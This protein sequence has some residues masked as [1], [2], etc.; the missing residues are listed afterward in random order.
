[1]SD[2][3]KHAQLYESLSALVDD[4]ASELEVHRLLAESEKDPSL[5]T[6]WYRYQLARAALRGEVV[7][8]SC[9][10][11]LSDQIRSAIAGLDQDEL[12]ESD[13]QHAAN[14]VPKA[15]E[16]RWWANAGRLAIAASVAGVVLVAAQQMNWMGDQGLG[17]AVASDSSLAPPAVAPA[18]TPS[19]LSAPT[20]NVETVSSGDMLVSP[21]RV[22]A[23]P[24][25]TPTMSAEQ[26]RL[27]EEEIR[28]YLQSLMNEHAQSA[29]QNN[30]GG[31]M[32][33]VRTPSEDANAQ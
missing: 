8:A 19:P 5:R 20:I 31:L 16:R 21:G 30:A 10:V 4:E 27:Q 12:S 33:Y 18:V 11:D 23:V 24:S 13:S 3:T 1:M 25:A 15:Q 22:R 14:D 28:Q 17:P 6:R 2:V 26:Q 7:A 9:S 32:P 29:S